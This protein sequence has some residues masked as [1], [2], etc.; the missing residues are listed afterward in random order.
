ML[1]NVTV[2]EAMK[3]S[4]AVVSPS[5]NVVSENSALNS[6]VRFGKQSVRRASSA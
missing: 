1:A 6:L 5:D 2:A 4:R 3:W